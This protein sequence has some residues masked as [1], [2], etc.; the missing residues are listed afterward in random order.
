MSNN[1]FQ[2]F[3][4][5]VFTWLHHSESF[6]I[7][8]VIIQLLKILQGTPTQTRN[9]YNFTNRHL[10]FMSNLSEPIHS[11]NNN[12]LNLHGHRTH[13]SQDI[14]TFFLSKIKSYIFI[15]AKHGL[16]HIFIKN[17]TNSRTWQNWNHSIWIFLTQFMN[18]PRIAL[19][20]PKNRNRGRERQWLTEGPHSSAT[21]R[22]EASS[23]ARDLIDSEVSRETEG[24]YVFLTSRRTCWRL[25][26]YWTLG[27]SPSGIAE[28]RRC[29]AVRRRIGAMATH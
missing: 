23:A 12:L 16:F 2:I 3:V 20:L 26:L 9:I 22:A 13:R 14:I 19:N 29:A 5:F 1:R 8:G 4:S 28:R 10:K 17:Y 6:I 18:F 21:Q 15:S 24:I 27:C 25:A 7:K 11:T